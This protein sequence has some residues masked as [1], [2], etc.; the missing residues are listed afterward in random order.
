MTG[1]LAPDG[2]DVH[3]LNCGWR[4]PYGPVPTWTERPELPAPLP[5][6][7]PK[8]R[9]TLYAKRYKSTEAYQAYLAYQKAYRHNRKKNQEAAQHER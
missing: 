9:R 3:C 7:R 6:H 5:Q 4:P 8:N 2:D 1:C